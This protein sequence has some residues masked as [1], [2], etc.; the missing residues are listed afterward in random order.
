MGADPTSD[1]DRTFWEAFKLH[2]AIRIKYLLKS[3]FFLK[4]FYYANPGEGIDLG[5]KLS[6][7][8]MTMFKLMWLFAAFCKMSPII[9]APMYLS[10]FYWI[11]TKVHSLIEK[12]AL[13]EIEEYS[14]ETGFKARKAIPIPEFD[15][16]N[17]D[18]EEF[19]ETYVKNPM[20]V[21]LRGF[22]SN[23]DAVK[24]WTFEQMLKDYGE[25]DVLLTT[26][27]LDG[28][29]GKLKEVDDPK[30]YLHNCEVL[31][32]RHPHLKDEL[33]LLRLRKYLKKGLGYL[34]MFIGRCGTGTP[35]HS[36]AVWNWF[37]MVEGKKT[38][39][40]VSPKN[41]ALM[42]PFM[43]LGKVAAFSLVAYP[44]E[45]DLKMFPLFKHCPY[46]EVTIGPGDVLLNP[47]WWWH[48]IKNV[49]PTSVAV[50]SRW[51]GNLENGAVGTDNMM[52]EENYEVSP[53]STLNF[54]LGPE[55]IPFLQSILKTPS[56]KFDEHKTVREKGNH[57]LHNQ[58]LSIK[59][60]FKV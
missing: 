27:E 12:R 28:I 22:S 32:E 15:W 33:E 7:T 54:F 8:T 24:K 37:T 34:Q 35:L 50:A 29:P 36:A 2:V 1:R 51:H 39:L 60:G 59:M 49:T 21:V 3:W 48:A 13:R 18:P 31:F 41:M 10:G 43:S 4:P 26:K 44:D 20:P 17:G 53:M 52:T 46:Y 57:K 16:E 5:P 14:K 56:P 11:V 40:F 42:Y 6:W 45:P 38:W 55:G 58:H 47:P 9:F 25:E 30:I 19:Y 23:T